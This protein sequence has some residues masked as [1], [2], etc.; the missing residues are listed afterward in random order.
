MTEREI[1]RALCD[2]VKELGGVAYKFVSPGHS[3]VPDRIVVL[4]GGV[5]GFVELKRTGEK[6]RALQRK[7][8]ENLGGRGC[9][10]AWVDR[11]EQIPKLLQ[12][13]Q[14]H[15]KGGTR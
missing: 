12:A 8:M 4:P 6:P 5:I 14:S 13:L 2:R 10:V 9:F 3:G 7:Q 15:H 1:E 11:V